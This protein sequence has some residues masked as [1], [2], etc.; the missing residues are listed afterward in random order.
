MMGTQKWEI[1]PESFKKAAGKTQHVADRISE[2]WQKLDTG[3]TAL[4]T[5]WGTDRTGRQFAE[6]D[7]GNGYVTTKANVGK[8]I[9]GGEGM[10]KSIE[11][12]ADGQSKTGDKVRS[13]LE[14]QNRQ[15]FE[16][17]K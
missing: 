1:D 5:P 12:L 16:T 3:L 8:G 15:S 13:E 17:R 4:G 7:G 14:A 9:V 10:T 2:V 6:G 11:N